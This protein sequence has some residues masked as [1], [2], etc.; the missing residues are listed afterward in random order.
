MGR[1][2]AAATATWAD[3][4]MHLIGGPQRQFDQAAERAMA[5]M[6]RR[7]ITK[8]VVFPPP[9]PMP[10][11]FDYG[12]YVGTVRRNPAKFA[13]LAG[14][15]T[16]NPAIQQTDP[17]AVTPAVRTQFVDDARRMLDAG[18]AG[19]GEIA[20]LHLSLVPN[21]PFE[22]TG[23]EH[24]LLY[25]L[26]EVAGERKAV[27]DLHMDAVPAPDL[28]TPQNLK[29]PP[30]PPRLHANIPGFERLLA[31]NRDARIVWAHGGS[32]MTGQLTPALI[33]RLM[34]AHPN[35]HMSLRPI[36]PRSA[37]ANPFNLSITNLLL[38]ESGFDPDW[39]ALLTK[40]PARFV[41]GGDAFFTAESVPPESAAAMLTRG[42]DN[43]L[44]AAGVVM[45]RLPPDLA[46]A[47]GH[48][49][50]ARLYR[51]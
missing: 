49:N 51:L 11:L 37:R 25:A 14:G 50:A 16:L 13:F 21:H 29:V 42:N 24:P 8:A 23:V 43:R 35:L 47:I 10:G 12:D 9:L 22:E 3:V 4:H 34:T 32:D 48:D 28:A 38:T 19:F 45:S 33:G 1:F 31:H 27:I 41:M 6:E 46:Q 18:A 20:V 17:A 26:V 7:G 30:N 40:F 39:L 44:T 36:V 15:G 2:A 5:E